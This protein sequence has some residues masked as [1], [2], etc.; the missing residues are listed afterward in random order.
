MFDVYLT[1]SVIPVLPSAVRAQSPMSLIKARALA[2]GLRSIENDP[3]KGNNLAS[4]EIE[5]ILTFEQ[6]TDF[7]YNHGVT[8]DSRASNNSNS[9]FYYTLSMWKPQK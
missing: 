8:L 7:I 5:N 9:I 4:I 1:V 6:P 3:V 2:D